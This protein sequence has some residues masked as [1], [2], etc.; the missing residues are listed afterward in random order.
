VRIV[1]AFTIACAL[2]LAVGSLV[3]LT[4]GVPGYGLA[5]TTV[6]VGAAGL[7]PRAR[8]WA[9]VIAFACGLVHGLFFAG[10]LGGLRVA[11]AALGASLAAFGAGIAVAVLAL[12]GGLYPLVAWLRGRSWGV[13]VLRGVSAAVAVA[14]VGLL[15]TRMLPAA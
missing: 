9:W 5:L 8:A 6:L 14:G 13:G 2:M 4:D 12:A 7:V 10:V 15:A 1:A 11:P 3:R